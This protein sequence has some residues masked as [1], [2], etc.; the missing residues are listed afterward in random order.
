MGKQIR[1]KVKEYM[2]KA[3]RRFEREKEE[4]WWGKK[5]QNKSFTAK[6]QQNFRLRHSPTNCMIQGHRST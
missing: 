4:K 1:E 6:F 3:R 5:T 2:R